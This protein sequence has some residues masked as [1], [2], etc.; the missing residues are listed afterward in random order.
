MGCNNSIDKAKPVD[1]KE[2][3]KKSILKSLFN[4]DELSNFLAHAEI[5]SYNPCDV[6]H[7][8]EFKIILVLSGS[9]SSY[10]SKSCE[11][12]ANESKNRRGSRL[13]E[14]LPTVDESNQNP[15]IVYG[16]GDLI[17]LPILQN[18]TQ[19]HPVVAMIDLYRTNKMKIVLKA[20]EGGRATILKITLEKLAQFIMSRN[21]SCVLHDFLDFKLSNLLYSSC[22]LFENLSTSQVSFIF[23]VYYYCY[24]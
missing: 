22:P 16:P 13:S 12:E 11:E 23:I 17:I 18:T 5:A 19:H 15:A 7:F 21:R 4:I 20:S 2:F 24:Q 8:D 14:V 6:I 9:I 10:I 1:P 3:V